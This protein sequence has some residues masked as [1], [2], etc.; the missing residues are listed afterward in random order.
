[1]AVADEHEIPLAR[2]GVVIEDV[3]RHWNISQPN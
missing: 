2:P 1:M 3:G